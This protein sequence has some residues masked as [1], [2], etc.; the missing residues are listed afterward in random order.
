MNIVRYLVLS[1]AMLL[2]IALFSS[3]SLACGVCF[4]APDSPLTAG[5]NM[6][7]LSLLGITG[8]VLGS[9]VTF[10]L[11][12]RRR[13]RMFVELGAHGGSSELGGLAK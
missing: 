3:T 7:I 11:K 9:F 13:A 8:G 4:G 5:M 10:F 2:C 12:L 1:A 6:G